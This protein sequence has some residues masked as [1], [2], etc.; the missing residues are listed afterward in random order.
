MVADSNSTSAPP[1]SSSGRRT[2]RCIRLED[3]A[4]TSAVPL[5]GKAE[6]LVRL[7][8]SGFD[9]P[10]AFVVVGARAG[11]LPP[12]LAE[13]YR[14]LG[15]GPVAVRSSAI[16]EDGAA[17]SFA[18]QFETVLGV[19]GEEALR[20]AIERCIASVSSA[21]ATAYREQRAAKD[22]GVAMC[23]VVQRMVDAAAAG[24]CFTVDPVL[25]RRDRLVI[26]AVRGLGEALVSGHVTPDHYEVDPRGAVVTRE[27]VGDTAILADEHIAALAAKARRAAEL[28]GHPLDLEWALDRGGALH[29]LQARPMTRLPA[30]P[31]ELDAGTVETDVWT[32]CNIGEM[33]PGAVSPLTLSVSGR[34]I[35]VGTQLFYRSIG[36]FREI[37]Y[38]RPVFVASF[39]NHLFLNLT[40]LG[41]IQRFLYGS[42]PDSLAMAICGRLVPELPEPERAP[43]YEQLW[44]TG[45]YILNF[46]SIPRIGARLEARVDA[47]RIPLESRARAQWEAIDARMQSLFD[48]YDLH[49][50]SSAGAGAMA[51]A[52]LAIVADGAEPT[53]AHHARV[54]ELLGGATKVESADIAE[55]ADRLAEVVA[56]QPEARE[57]FAEATDSEALAWIRS[58]AAGE[59]R[60][61]FATYLDKHGHRAVRE[62]CLRQKEWSEDPTPVIQSLKASVLARA[63]GGARRARPPAVDL[64]T[65][66]RK[67]RHVV[68]LARAMVRNRERTK[69]LLIRI[70]ARFKEAYRNLGAL[71]VREGALPDADLVFFLTHAELGE[72][73]AAPSARLAELAESRR[74]ALPIQASMSFPEVFVGT[75]E[76]LPEGVHAASEVVSLRG[77]PVSTG[78][79]EGRACVAR[80]LSEASQ[81]QPGDI[82]VTPIT[83]V[84]WTPYFSV[85]AG[86]ATD[87]G[88]A[89]SHGAVVA[90]EYGMPAV[91]G[92]RDATSRFRTG[93]RVRLDGSRGVLELLAPRED[94]T[95][96][97]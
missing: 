43:L 6:G 36:G 87:V 79:V 21:R 68:P 95:A 35:D 38:D 61:L 8:A 94:D 56:R 80:T 97:R 25:G 31:R 90:R 92:L 76:P 55:G 78:V 15:G 2:A 77:K 70:T 22:E 88:S 71:L 81:V 19:V 86:L 82:L 5:G 17:A 3:A 51:P 18:G 49:L 75:P 14:A 48:A 37:R 9:V 39:A 89:V 58:S 1:S 47:F 4:T 12:D 59:A 28:E 65:L 91:V 50:R 41:K 93:D 53:E 7:L 44:V 45:R 32:R 62:A 52:L 10:P 60:E 85:I 23:V 74:V 24:V 67:L 83:D 96:A 27:L 46:V 29:F 72:F 54:A 73:T 34:G 20:A 16:G 30:D 66:P 33:M 11:H 40:E 13:A 69:S 57:R 63:R 64:A 42:T 26:D 84:G